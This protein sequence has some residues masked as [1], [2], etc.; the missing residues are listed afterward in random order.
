M[1][2]EERMGKGLMGLVGGGGFIVG[3]VPTYPVVSVV[4]WSLV[5]TDTDSF[6]FSS[7]VLVGLGCGLN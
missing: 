3:H 5:C 6:F 2:Q 4:G 7:W 1:R